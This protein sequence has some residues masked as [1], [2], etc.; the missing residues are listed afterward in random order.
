MD[1]EKL[2]LEI[3]FYIVESELCRQI[4]RRVCTI[5]FICWICFHF[6]TSFVR[7]V[8]W[9][10]VSTNRAYHSLCTAC[11]HHCTAGSKCTTIIIES[12]HSNTTN[13]LLGSHRLPR[14]GRQQQNRRSLMFWIKIDLV[15]PTLPSPH[16][17]GCSNQWEMSWQSFSI[18]SIQKY[19]FCWSRVVAG[20]ETVWHE[21][22]SQAEW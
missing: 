9:C 1:V 3:R 18:E 12:R 20:T 17:C 5:S 8:L 13:L 7:R 14:D 6:L 11:V 21:S 19:L 10:F 4:S 2:F 22:I 15:G 16:N